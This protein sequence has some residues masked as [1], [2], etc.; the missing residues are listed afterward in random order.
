A[1]LVSMIALFAIVVAGVAGTAA[2]KSAIP[3]RAG[4]PQWVAI[5]STA[6]ADLL[7]AVK[8][9][10]AYQSVAHAPQTGLGAALASGTLDAPVLVHAYHPTPGMHDVW[11][12]P[13]HDATGSVV[14]LLDFAYDAA[15][16]RISAQTFAGPFVASD[17][18]YGHPF[19]R[20]SPATALATFAR[21]E[22]P[23]LA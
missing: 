6:A 13:V 12:V 19:P 21:V 14:A 11:V 2:G 8:S 10:S 1:F 4:T 16:R 3:P 18:E 20:T 15:G 7:A 22:G 5:R 9:S 17:P 23:G